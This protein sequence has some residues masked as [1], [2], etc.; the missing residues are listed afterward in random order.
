MPE[1]AFQLGDSWAVDTDEDGFNN[2]PSASQAASARSSRVNQ[3]KPKQRVLRPVK[4]NNN[5]SRSIVR[6]STPSE[7][8]VGEVLSSSASSS[9]S[10]TASENS[11]S[12]IL[13]RGIELN[14]ENLLCL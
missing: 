7:S 3:N 9:R 5:S 13:Q 1:Q 8:E 12:R 6:Q 14:F 2:Q 4:P 11:P 10:F